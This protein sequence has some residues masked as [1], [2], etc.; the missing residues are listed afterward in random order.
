MLGFKYLWG[1]PRQN[2]GQGGG[3]SIWGSL[4]TRAESG[5]VQHTKPNPRARGGVG[6]W[7]SRGSHGSGGGMSFWGRSSDWKWF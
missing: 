7:G 5:I 3:G 2:G 1:P 4:W 6:F